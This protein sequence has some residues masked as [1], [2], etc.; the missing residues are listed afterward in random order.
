MACAMLCMHVVQ[1]T[2]ISINMHEKSYI[3]IIQIKH[4]KQQKLA[5]HLVDQIKHR[6]QK[7]PAHW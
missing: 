1:N 7:Y 5:R 6:C 4:V 3:Q 2:H